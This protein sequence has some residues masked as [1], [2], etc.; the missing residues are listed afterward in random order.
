L[1]QTLAASDGVAG[2]FFGSSDA[3]SG[4]ASGTTVVIGAPHYTDIPP[5][6]IN[7]YIDNYTVGRGA[8]YVFVRPTSGTSWSQQQKLTAPDGQDGDAFGSAVAIDR[9]KVFIGAPYDDVDYIDQGSVNVFSRSQGVWRWNRRPIA[10]DGE[11]QDHFGYSVAI[12]GSTGRLLIG[13]PGDDVGSNADQG[14]AH[15]FTQFNPCCVPL[16]WTRQQKLTAQDGAAGDQFGYSVAIYRDTLVVGAPFDDFPGVPNQ[17][18]AYVFLRDPTAWS[19]QHKLT[20]SD[21]AAKDQFGYSVAISSNSSYPVLGSGLP[22]QTQVD[23]FTFVVVGAPF[24][25]IGA[26]PDQGSA[27]VFKRKSNSTSWG[28]YDQKLTATSGGVDMRFGSAIAVPPIS[29]QYVV[30]GAPYR[31]NASGSAYVF[32]SN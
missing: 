19:Q 11:A 6:G 24:Q 10:G 26:N 15:V 12:D 16:S 25:D 32:V 22:G 20:A 21:G 18:S 31:N 7:Y 29:A 17:G 8:A 14:S 4:N 28:S 3:I 23:E 27:Y 2:D 30:V 1:Q 5:E 9:D 13:A